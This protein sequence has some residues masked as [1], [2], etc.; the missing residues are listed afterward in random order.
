[1]IK[2]SQKGKQLQR[3]RKCIYNTH[4]AQKL[5]LVI[6][7]ALCSLLPLHAQVGIGTTSPKAAL[8]I[9]STNSG[10][11]IPR[12]TL[13][14]VTD[15]TTVVNPND[16]FL[17]ESTLVYNTVTGGLTPAGFYYWD[18]NT[19]E[20]ITDNSSNVYMGKVEITALGEIDVT[21][22]FTPSPLHPFLL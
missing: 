6:V 16:A 21:L 20:A 18:G 14:A 8:D 3:S 7:V 2:V 15:I 10:L 22:P 17:V 11:L 9:S 4:T 19:W 12:V 1:M 13:D 5:W